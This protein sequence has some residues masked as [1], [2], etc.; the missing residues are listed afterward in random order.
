[1]HE[2]NCKVNAE[3]AHCEQLI[4]RISKGIPEKEFEVQQQTLEEAQSALLMF[5]K[6]AELLHDISTTS[7]GCISMN[8]GLS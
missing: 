8:S 2:F 3:I 1:M 5:E 4:L 6:V 7:S